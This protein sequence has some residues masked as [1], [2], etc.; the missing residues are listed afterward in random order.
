MCLYFKFN[1]IADC[2]DATEIFV[3]Q[4]YQKKR[5]FRSLRLMELTLCHSKIC[6]FLNRIYPLPIQTYSFP[7][8]F[9]SLFCHGSANR[10]LLLLDVGFLCFPED[11][12]QSR[13]IKK[14]STIRF[15][16]KKKKVE[17]WWVISFFS[18]FLSQKVKDFYRL[19]L[20]RILGPG[21]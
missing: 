9:F 6:Y 7:P 5:Y 14:F 16:L 2:Y 17:V 3:E 8:V 15:Y 10:S 1:V 18:F 20:R 11:V 19:V 12:F 4:Y 21:S 13:H